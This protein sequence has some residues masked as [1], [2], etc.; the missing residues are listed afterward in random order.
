MRDTS[1]QA[2]RLWPKDWVGYS[3]II[4]GEWA[5]QKDCF[6]LFLG[7]VAPPWYLGAYSNQQE[8]SPQTPAFGLKLN[9]GLTPSPTQ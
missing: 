1:R 2:R 3:F 6:C 9:A 4:Q 7:V 8:G 5:V